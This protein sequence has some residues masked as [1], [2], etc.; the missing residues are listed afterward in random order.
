M[1]LEDGMV[2][3]W[4]LLGNCR[5]S[6][7]SGNHGVSH[8]VEWAA[9]GGRFN[10][11]DSY[12]EVPDDPSLHLGEREFSLTAW[13]STDAKLDDVLG[14]ILTKYD[15]DARTGFNLCIQNFHGVTSS[16]SNYRNLFFGID[17][18]KPPKWV[19]CGRPGE[20]VLVWSLCVHMGSLYAGTFEMGKGQS[21]HMY[22]YDGGTG[23]IDCGSPHPSNAITSL[24]VYDG[25][26]YAA[27]S[28]YRSS[29]SAL[30]ESENTTPGGRVFRY[31]GGKEWA[32][33]GQV[34]PGESIGGLAVFSG[35]LYASSMYAP[36]G[37]Y[38]YEGGRE[39]RDCG[40][41]GGRV[42]ALGV[43]HGCLY[44]SGWDA[45][46]SG[47]YRYEGGSAWSDCGTPPGNTQTY[48]FAIHRGS[49]CVGTWPS[50]RVFRMTREGW[51]DCGRLG[52]EME[53]MGM[54]LYNGKLYAGTL[55]S[56]RVYRYDGGCDW[57][58]TGQLD[59]TPDV[60]Y[61]RAW[62]MAVYRGRLFCGTLPSGHVH[63]LTAGSCVT[64]DRELEAGWQHIAAI[65]RSHELRLL[66][67][68]RTVAREKL[69]NETFDVTNTEPLMIG[70]GE[71]AYFKGSLRDV[72]I[73]ARALREGEAAQLRD[74][75]PPSLPTGRIQSSN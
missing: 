11:T 16:Q 49:L 71:H 42:E 41:P 73:Y 47:V 12:V 33:C 14:D 1:N 62:S 67:N 61:R 24:A 55:P 58:D 64:H 43:Y 36:P 31:E 70:F 4:K 25:K 5:D 27:A 63:S 69:G 28:H 53:V 22:R 37:L 18:G 32:D 54:A 65:R 26:L 21:G 44:G 23:W 52:E 66:V 10:G 13:V 51:Q 7:G 6:S 35:R 60:R 45:G 68:G 46:R 9:N 75:D 39:W 40:N 3:R 74:C 57:V 34:G 56:A 50:G 48:S 20:A 2:A 72:R 15:A 59:A 38:R 8:G 19:D 17:A 30:P 29:G